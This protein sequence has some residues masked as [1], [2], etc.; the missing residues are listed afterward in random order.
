MHYLATFDLTETIGWTESILLSKKF[1]LNWYNKSTLL[2]DYYFLAEIVTH[3]KKIK[4]I[5]DAIPFFSAE[6]KQ[7]IL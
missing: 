2:M 6:I 5:C 1:R 4:G 7:I 3:M